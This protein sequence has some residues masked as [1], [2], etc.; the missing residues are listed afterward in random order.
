METGAAE[1]LSVESL[2][3]AGIRAVV[4]PAFVRTGLGVAGPS[5]NRLIELN[6]DTCA[7]DARTAAQLPVL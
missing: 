3:I 1:R 6:G 4:V 7:G 5:A 2:T